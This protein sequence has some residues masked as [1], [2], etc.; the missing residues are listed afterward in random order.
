M[1]NCLITGVLLYFAVASPVTYG[2]DEYQ[3]VIRDHRFE[4]AEISIPADKRVKLIV[5]NQDETVEEFESKALRVEKLIP[6]KTNATIW[7]GPLKAG[8]YTFVGEFHEDTAQ[9]VLISE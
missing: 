8:K 4:P 2:N 9:G 7:V 5:D 1:K 3:L 6:G